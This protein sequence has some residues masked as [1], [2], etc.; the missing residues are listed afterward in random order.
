[1]QYRVVLT[2]EAEKLLAAIRDKR[3]LK[4]LISRIEQLAEN[5]EQ[6]GKALRED[7]AGYRALRAVG[8][9]Y[10]IVYRIEEDAVLVVVVALGRRKDGDGKAF[11]G[12]RKDVYQLAQKLVQTFQLKQFLDEEADE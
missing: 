7:L 2:D 1:V 9:R 12:N 8:Q 11:Q 6:Q 10:R 3:E 5:P 4:L